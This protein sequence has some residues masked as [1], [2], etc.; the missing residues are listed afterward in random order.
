[1]KR[2]I[3]KRKVAQ[4]SEGVL[5]TATDL[6]LAEIF[7]AFEA[8]EPGTSARPG[9]IWKAYYRS[10]K[11]L[12]QINYQTL[13][14]A[15]LY[16]KRRGLINYV[17]EDI[18]TL[19][20]ITKQGLERLNGLFP[21]YYK[22]RPWDG[23]I[24]LVAYDIPE[25]QRAERDKLRE[26]LKKIGCGMLQASVW[27]TP[28]NPREVLQEF[29]KEKMLGGAVIISDVGKDGSIG[30]MTVKELVV[31]VYD[32]HQISEDYE[33]F[34]QEF[35]R[36]KGGNITPSQAAFRFFAILNEDP[37]LPFELLPLDWKG[38]KAYELF[39]KITGKAQIEEFWEE[40]VEKRI[41]QIVKE[42]KAQEKQAKTRQEGKKKGGKRKE[43]K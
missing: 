38:D 43:T 5:A 15:F 11:D 31:K 40:K 13:K 19:P 42:E 14:R 35:R 21:K 3:L 23:K 17:K 18:F 22:E 39:K 29:I 8:I 25:E 6:V 32:L 37:Q 4:I 7:F 34:L 2:K 1:M 10:Q 16:L 24:Y 36:K 9:D 41:E 26:H 27:L 33:D 28:Y 12:Q 20:E 30:Q